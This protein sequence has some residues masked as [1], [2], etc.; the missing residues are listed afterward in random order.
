[1]HPYDIFK[2]SPDWSMLACDAHMRI[3]TCDVFICPTGVCDV[4]NAHLPDC[5]HK[6]TSQV[7]LCKSVVLSVL[8]RPFFFFAYPIMHQDQEPTSNYLQLSCLVILSLG[9]RSHKWGHFSLHPEVS[10]SSSL[11]IAQDYPS[12]HLYT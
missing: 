3:S 1:M 7:H 10:V 2:I 8:I 5:A 9:E 4:Q 12:V 6:H 11:A